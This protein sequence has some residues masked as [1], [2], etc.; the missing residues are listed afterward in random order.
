M[1]KT[2]CVRKSPVALAI[3]GC[4]LFTATPA[5]SDA[6]YTSGAYST[7]NGGFWNS[8]TGDYSTI[9]GGLGNEASSPYAAVGGGWANDAWK[10]FATIA[11]GQYNT[12]RGDHVAI[13]GGQNNQASG[14]FTTIAGGENNYSTGS[15]AFIGG[16]YGNSAPGAYAVVI[17]GGG[18]LSSKSSAT[19]G[20][21]SENWANAE[22]AVV[23][24]GQ[25]NTASGE[26]AAIPGGYQNIAGGAY[27]FA[28]G[29]A[30][31]VRSASESGTPDGDAGSFVW[32]DSTEFAD[33]TTTGP[34]QFLV[35]ANGGMALNTLPP[36]PG[37]A[38]T[39][40]ATRANPSYGTVLL[41]PSN[42]SA[43]IL[44]T[45]GDANSTNNSGFYIDQYNG[46]VQNRRLSLDGNGNLTVSAQAY[47]PGGGAWAASSDQRLKTNI[48]PIATALDRILALR[49]VTF[50]Y[51]HPDDGM[52]P[53]GTFTGFVAQEVE[54]VFPNWIG[55]DRDGYLTVGPT[56]FEALT[57]EA[58]REL[59]SQDEAKMA[60][61]T[62]ENAKLK[63]QLAQQSDRLNA[64][65]SSV[66]S[67]RSELAAVAVMA[68]RGRLPRAQKAAVVAS[69][70][71]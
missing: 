60:D 29:Y 33:T 38:L 63:E 42:K 64:T 12:A 39:V 58:L 69:A 28:G 50:E 41:R 71:P 14:S 27:S 53:A 68:E 9:S 17:G 49:G 66:A 5:W 31:H 56:G 22:Y 18:N 3:L 51:A 19:V 20:G 32:A 67:L 57:V 24:G 4:L 45:A 16:G 10:D 6:N 40:E 26:S 44:L 54:K 34:N 11:G 8:A 47:K 23:A 25:N 37:I 59:K 48:Q 2:A 7:A 21:G 61:L 70:T 15:H 55:H 46:S 65:E 43:G 35:R 30:A 13:G 62:R 52:H 1:N 36:N